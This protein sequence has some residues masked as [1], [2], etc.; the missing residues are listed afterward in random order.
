[1]ASI[2]RTDRTPDAGETEVAGGPSIEREP[3]RPRLKALVPTS[4]FGRALVIILTPL[5]LM[6]VIST[7]VFYD[8]HWDTMSRRLSYDIAGDIA[9]LID[10]LPRPVTPESLASLDLRSRR[11]LDIAIDFKPGETL[12]EAVDQP[13]W[14]RVV[15]TL[16]DALRDKVKKPFVIDAE[17]IHRRI[18]VDVQLAGGVLTAITHQKRLYSSTTYIFLMWMIGSALVLFAIA[19][20]FMRNQ[21]RPIR[22][23][24]HAATR[25]G[26][27]REVDDFRPAGA[28]EVRQAAAAFLLMQDRISRQITQRTEMLAG[29]SHDL[30]TPLTR[31]KLQLAM[32]E[33][34]PEIQELRDDVQDMERMVE[35]YL[36]FARG[37]GTETPVETD[38]AALVQ[39]MVAV[40]RRDG[41]DLAVDASDPAG[42]G[43]AA[44]LVEVRPNALK[45]ALANLLGNAK[46]HAARVR[47]SLV[48]LDGAIDILVDD[49]G[50]GIP[51]DQRDRVFRPF[52]RL[53][54]SRNPATGGTGL[55][56]TI[57]RDIAR[58]HGGDITLEDSPLGGLRARLH[59]PA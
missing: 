59:L 51:A 27:G 9:L 15:P 57:A 13:F 46:R 38:V 1:M 56:L 29:V 47:V 18:K 58:N 40:E 10:Q 55:G 43:A 23:L 28:T 2:G 4:L 52:F 24:A 41:F 20:V 34:G 5:L 21:I 22:R 25:F 39:D 26:L 32:L 33:E 3:A 31:M 6:Q 11:H 44:D 50:P 42:E 35:G 8:R 30:R 14:D 19:I 37:E 16:A 17:G 53:E 36:A 49:D 45:R 48:R 7:F 12:P 54:S